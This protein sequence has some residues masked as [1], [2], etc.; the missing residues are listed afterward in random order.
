MRVG[1]RLCTGK[2]TLLVQPRWRIRWRNPANGRDALY[3]A[4]HTCG[5]EGIAH[6]E[7]LALI[8]DLVARATAPG[9]TYLHHWRPGD[10]IMWDNRATLHRGR[11]WP[12]DQPRHMVRTT[13]TATDADG[14]KAMYPTVA[15][16]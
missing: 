6:D 5:I 8:D 13:I 16:A 11:P 3:V 9:C 1:K 12:D 2:K 7:A 14:L 4:S 10:V 15:A